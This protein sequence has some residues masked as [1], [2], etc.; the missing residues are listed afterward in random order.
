[1]ADKAPYG[2]FLG[3]VVDETLT[4]FAEAEKR[5]PGWTVGATTIT[6]RGVLKPMPV[7][8]KPDKWQLMWDVDEPAHVAVTE[9]PVP[10][11]RGEQI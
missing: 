9:V 6:I 10:I 8:G 2:E 5:N 3:R 11:R 7:P 1:M 4:A